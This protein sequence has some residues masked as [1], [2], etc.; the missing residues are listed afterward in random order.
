ML[1]WFVSYPPREKVDDEGLGQGRG[2]Q[3][4]ELGS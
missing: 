3:L 2:F 4:L 1:R